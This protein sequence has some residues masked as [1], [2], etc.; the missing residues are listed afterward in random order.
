MF[1]KLKVALVASIL[2]FSVAA[3][4]KVPA[5]NV[6]VMVD[7][8]GD[9]K[10]VSD[11]ELGP[12]RYWVGFY[13]ELYTFPTFTQ[14]YCWTK[15]NDP[16]CGST[17]DESI[18]FQTNEGLVVSADVGISYRVLP[19]AAPMIFQKYRKGVQEITDT[20]LRNYV[21]DA[22][23]NFGASRSIEEVY[24]KGKVALMAQVEKSIKDQMKP[25]GIDIE[26]I[27][28]IGNIRLPPKV[29]EALNAKIAATQ[30]AQQRQNEIA[31]ARAEADKK[32]E[33]ARGQAESV[34]I[35]AKAQAEANKILAQSLTKELVQ[36]RAID[37]WDGVLPRFSGGA[38][39]FIQIPSS[40]F[41]KKDAVQK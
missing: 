16:K 39:P 11:K 5:G 12:G 9:G 41:D 29:V 22:L 32:I 6:G 24:G 2:A 33:E 7:L 28:W 36:Y 23:V 20:Y 40:E 15:T 18:S 31:Q 21:R 37:R 1:S 4:G 19:G 35:N 26:N 34:T 10:G 8:Y 13:Q 38:L 27:Y 14:N 30:K 17:N 3:C 25:L